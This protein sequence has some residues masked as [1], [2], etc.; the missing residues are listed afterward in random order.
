MARLDM[1]YFISGS[2]I[3]KREWL[4][5]GGKQMRKEIDEEYMFGYF[6]EMMQT[7]PAALHPLVAKCHDPEYKI[8][9]KI[10]K[11]LERMKL[12]K[13]GVVDK[14]VA[15]FIVGNIF[16][17]DGGISMSSLTI[18]KNTAPPGKKEMILT[19]ETAKMIIY[20]M[21]YSAPALLRQLA[22]K[23]HNPKHEIPEDLKKMLG[24]RH[25]IID[26]K[27]PGEI[28]GFIV[29]K[30]RLTEKNGISMTL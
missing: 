28:K 2:A 13:N 5:T 18:K 26:G 8:N 24:D 1:N 14:N 29:Q 12:M 11:I 9:D 10:C 21:I 6:S 16:L 15:R 3:K 7:A 25:L 22:E 23:C 30:I 4:H 19:E 27:I 17:K 20:D